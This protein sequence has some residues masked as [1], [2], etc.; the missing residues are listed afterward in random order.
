MCAWPTTAE[1]HSLDVR[2]WTGFPTRPTSLIVTRK[3][4]YQK[5]QKMHSKLITDDSIRISKGH[6][7]RTITTQVTSSQSWCRHFDNNGQHHSA[8]TPNG[9]YFSRACLAWTRSA[10]V[11][12]ITASLLSA[13]L[14]TNGQKM[15]IF[16]HF[17]QSFFTSPF[18]K[19]Q[20]NRTTASGSGRW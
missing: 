10:V 15:F 17:T 16:L 13:P 8:H 5:F 6:E 14:S 20:P 3:S 7:T 1:S 19:F 12:M 2:P 18:S 9:A 4:E 11:K